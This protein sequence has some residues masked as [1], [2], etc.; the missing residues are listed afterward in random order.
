MRTHLH[1]ATFL[2]DIEFDKLILNANAS[3]SAKNKPIRQIAK[4]KEKQ[5]MKRN[6]NA[7][8]LGCMLICPI[9]KKIH[10][11]PIHTAKCM[12]TLNC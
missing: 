11:K 9:F 2:R 1:C 12:C 3:L 7:F 6:A 10:I 8:C 4:S 5:Q